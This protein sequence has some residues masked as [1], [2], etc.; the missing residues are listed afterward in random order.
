MKILKYCLW[1]PFLC[2]FS[3]FAQQTSPTAKTVSGTVINHRNEP[4]ANANVTI[5]SGRGTITNAQGKFSLKNITDDDILHISFVGYTSQSIPVKDQVMFKVVL[6]PT[7]NELD[8]VVV[9]AYGITSKRLA[10]GNIASVSAEEIEKHPVMNPVRILQGMVPGAV[11]TSGTGFSSTS[12]KI[13]IRGRNTIDNSLVSDPLYV[14]DG[15]PMTILNINSSIKSY[16]AG[17][18]VSNGTVQAGIASEVGQGQ[19]P[20]FSIN[21]NDIESIEV[22]KDA[23]ATAI[24]GSR[25]ANGVILITTKK[26]KVGKTRSELN[27]YS[28]YSQVPRYYPLM[29]TQQYVTMRKEAL[30][31]DGLPVN[32]QTAPDLIA[33]DTTR[34][35]DWQ[36][37]I[38]GGIGRR[39][40]AQAS[41]SG[42]DT[43]TNFRASAGYDYEKELVVVN[44]GNHRETFALNLNH[45]SLNNKLLLSWSTL[46][47]LTSINATKKSGSV[48][49]PP[50]APAV[51]NDKE[52]L[53]YSGWEPL[54]YAFPFSG[55]LESY[56]SKSNLFNSNI[57]ISYELLDGLTVSANLG[58]NSSQNEQSKKYPIAS[59]NPTSNPRGMLY[60]GNTNF[61]NLIIEPKVE[62]GTFI[63]KGKLTLLVGGTIQKNIT[64][65]IQ[66]IGTNYTSD[67]FLNSINGAPDKGAIDNYGEYKYAGLFG[68][69][70]YNWLNKYIL[71]L[72]ARR[73]GSSRFGP[74]RQMGNFGSVGAAWVFSEYQWMKKLSFLSFGKIRASYG[75]TG[76]DEISD[77]RYL[78][79]WRFNASGTYNSVLPI[80]PIGF[81]DSLLQWEVNKK[82]EASIS[83]SL[84]NERVSFDLS[85][86]RN[87]CNNQ[88]VSFP[89]PSFTGFTSV[90]SNTPANV[91]NKGWE[92][93][94]NGKIFDNRNFG[95]TLKA[96]IAIN[97]N[98]LISY[99]NF[100]QSP[101]KARLE[102]GKPLNIRKLLKFTGVDPETGLYTFEDF[103]KDDIIVTNPNLENNDFYSVILTPKYDGG[104]TT[105]LR[106]KNFQLSAFFYFR[107]QLG[108]NILSTSGLPGNTSNQSVDVL[109]RWQHPGDVTTFGFFSTSNTTNSE[110]YFNYSDAQ[111]TDAS[112]IRLQNVSISYQWPQKIMKRFG[113]ND[114]KIYVQAE[115]LFIITNYNGIDPE[116]QTLGAMP[117]PRI[118]TFG[119]TVNL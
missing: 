119:L 17:S 56:V 68:R 42:G 107:K 34:Y 89:T 8:K 57:A 46:Y 38:F 100:S 10:T 73:D 102:I 115:N 22:L 14:V 26:G 70:N 44:G 104:I 49:T 94:V 54:S 51:F 48:L 55:L 47:S 59:Q 113:L 9:Q 15:V 72:N 20:F 96:N 32:L 114:F 109:N 52:E 18:I 3:T 60:I 50:N 86:Y 87:R 19:S 78:S 112:F 98:K 16:S 91:E 2:A 90:T 111:I 29:N 1:I 82:I 79:L 117:F 69:I 43:R 81:S 110:N 39:L 61:Q 24:Y 41:I 13:E 77:Y 76:S 105:N 65:A 67:L 23:D 31:N 58:Y 30:A 25:A 66:N 45:K 108:S 101:Y 71:N 83:L 75:L 7:E 27:V 36:K 95:W 6:Q 88:L 53:N 4:L 85:W 80:F 11:V 62:Y 35:T 116:V 93:V 106:Y 118:V 63:R 103:N 84:F 64:K 92:F 97:K 21:P 99:P 28:G 37:Y 33:W 5:T 12:V 40:N 74:G